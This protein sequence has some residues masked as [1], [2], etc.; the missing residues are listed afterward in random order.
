LVTVLHAPPPV[1]HVVHVPVQVDNAQHAPSLHTPLEQA[2]LTVHAEPPPP[3]AT[4]VAA[5]LQ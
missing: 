1:A 4:H 2:T 3:C 5:A